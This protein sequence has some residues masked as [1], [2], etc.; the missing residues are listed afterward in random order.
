MENKIISRSIYQYANQLQIIQTNIYFSFLVF[1]TTFPPSLHIVHQV[2]D[3][4]GAGLSPT[5][6]L[7]TSDR[8]DP[9]TDAELEAVLHVVEFR[10]T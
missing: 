6:A 7:V 8:V 5:V 2:D 10:N 4:E 3:G 1:D 9:A